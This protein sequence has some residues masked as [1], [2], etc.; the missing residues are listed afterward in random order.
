M[1]KSVTGFRKFSTPKGK[2][3]K[4]P[5]RKK[6]LNVDVVIS[7][8]DDAVMSESDG[9]APCSSKPITEVSAIE[10]KLT[11]VTEKIRSRTED[12][13]DDDDDENV[14]EQEDSEQLTDYRKININV[15]SNIF[16]FI[17]CS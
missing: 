14:E 3:R 6:R 5:V 4:G 16:F 2:R 17:C 10:S 15:L 9:D 7:T 8:E 12:D 13:D 11:G 1:A